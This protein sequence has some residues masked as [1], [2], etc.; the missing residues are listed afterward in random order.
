MGIKD[1]LNLRT[2]SEFPRTVDSIRH[3]QINSAYQAHFKVQKDVKENSV[4]HSF[5]FHIHSMNIES[6]SYIALNIE[7]SSL[8]REQTHIMML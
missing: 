3:A 7:L 1:Q 6:L 8:S 4:R 5:S 2:G